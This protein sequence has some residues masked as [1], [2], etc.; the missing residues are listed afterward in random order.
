[1]ANN[2]MTVGALTS[3]ILY[4]AYTAIS[5]GGLSNFYTELNKG[6][7]SASRLW[8]ILDRKCVIPVTGKSSKTK[9]LN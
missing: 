7:G 5:I 1:V 3:F 4:A 2:E 8:E 9:M 6:I